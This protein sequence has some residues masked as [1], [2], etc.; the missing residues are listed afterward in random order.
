MKVHSSVTY[1]QAKTARE[2]L[3]LA[4]E[5]TFVWSSAEIKNLKKLLASK[6]MTNPYFVNLYQ[7]KGSKI[8]WDVNKE[9]KG[10]N[11][12]RFS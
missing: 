8:I 4:S 12:R 10:F 3:K 6:S 9:N 7:V 5:D 2:A 11:I 1:T